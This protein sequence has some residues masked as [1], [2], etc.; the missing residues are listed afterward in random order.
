MQCTCQNHD[1]RVHPYGLSGHEPWRCA[2]HWSL[3]R[4][5]ARMGRTNLV[6]FVRAFPLGAASR[7]ASAWDANDLAGEAMWTAVQMWADAGALDAGSIL[8]K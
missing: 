4:L 6:T 1:S 7:A 5:F 8:K 3:E 2:E